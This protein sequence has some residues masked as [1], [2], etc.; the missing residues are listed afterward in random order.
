M[1]FAIDSV[2]K[3]HKTISSNKEGIAY[4]CFKKKYKLK[5]AI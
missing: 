5:F 1:E 3:F 4:F 2:T